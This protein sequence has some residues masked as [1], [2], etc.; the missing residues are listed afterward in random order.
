M[1]CPEVP[2]S[3]ARI[4]TLRQNVRDKRRSVIVEGT[5]NECGAFYG[6]RVMIFA[7][8]VPL[9]HSGSRRVLMMPQRAYPYVGSVEL[10][11]VIGGNTNRLYW[12]QIHVL[13]LSSPSNPARPIKARNIVVG[14]GITE[15]LP[16][17][18]PGESVPSLITSPSIVPTPERIPC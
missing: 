11:L 9:S 13:R 4:A 3:A 10:D 15:V 2:N 1:N 7:R 6:E 16:A 17:L 12:D 5:T 14:S 18:P 8:N